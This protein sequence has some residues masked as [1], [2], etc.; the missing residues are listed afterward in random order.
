MKRLSFYSMVIFAVIIAVYCI[1]GMTIAIAGEA[2]LVIN[3][4][5]GKP[6]DKIVFMGS[7]FQAEE[8]IRVI[9]NDGDVPYVFGAVGTG[10]IVV[11]KDDGTFILEPRGGIPKAISGPGTY[12]IEAIGDKGTKATAELKILPKE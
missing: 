1:G 5:E 8:K 4:S 10:G 11:A 9:L 2:K 6:G 12:V 7:G 3:P